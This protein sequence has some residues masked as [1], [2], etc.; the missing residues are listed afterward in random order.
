MVMDAPLT[1]LVPAPRTAPEQ[2]VRLSEDLM[3]RLLGT[4]TAV[5]AAGLKSFGLLL[6][7]P[8]APGFPYVATDVAFFDPRKNR[9]N[10][11]AMRPAFEAQGTYFRSYDDAGFVADASELLEV[12]RGLDES[13]LEAVA[14]FHV[15]RRQPANFSVIDFRL[16]NPAYAWHL[17]ISLRDPADPVLRAFAVR[18]D[19]SADLGISPDED[20]EG[21]EQSYLGPEVSPLRLTFESRGDAVAV[22]SSRFDRA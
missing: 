18:K 8:R 13:G 4:T 16:H 10:D 1:A 22:G 12:Y 19:P 2:E 9:R 14:L 5:H 11:P 6:A 21:S 17:I 20:N 3:D 7:D 15:H